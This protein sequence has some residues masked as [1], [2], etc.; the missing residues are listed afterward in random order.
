VGYLALFSENMIKTMSS[1]LESYKIV[2]VYGGSFV[3][4]HDIWTKNSEILLLFVGSRSFLKGFKRTKKRKYKVNDKTRQLFIVF[5]CSRIFVPHEY[6][7]AEQ[8]TLIPHCVRV[9]SK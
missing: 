4:T 2:N 5:F 1:G 9:Y 3:G 8:A 6:L 7:Y